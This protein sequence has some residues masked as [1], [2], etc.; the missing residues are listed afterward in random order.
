M[1]KHV[2]SFYKAEFKEAI[3]LV[4]ISIISF[5]AGFVSIAKWGDFGAGI[6]V[7]FGGFAIGYILKAFWTLLV[8]QNQTE[9]KMAEFEKDN[10][11]FIKRETVEIEKDCQKAQKSKPFKMVSFLVGLFF[12]LMGAF[13]NWSELALGFGVGLSVQSAI[14]LCLGLLN[15]YRASFYL[16]KLK[17]GKV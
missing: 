7:T 4:F 8:E 12:V 16:Q 3:W 1:I 11:T 5:M 14:L 9:R 2:E 17:K 13:G 10:A 6:L 15:D